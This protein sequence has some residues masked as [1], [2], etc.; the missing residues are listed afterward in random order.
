MHTVM[1]CFYITPPSADVKIVWRYTSSFFTLLIPC[2]VIQ[3]L[4]LQPTKC[5]VV[6]QKLFLVFRAMQVHHQ[7][8]SCSIQALSKMLCPS[9]YGIMVNHHRV[10]YMGWSG[11]TA[12]L[13]KGI[14]QPIKVI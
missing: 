5:T 9:V 8:L 3:L 7:E 13:T 12:V 11:Y 6:S 10:L 1:H 4:Q 14:I 2:T